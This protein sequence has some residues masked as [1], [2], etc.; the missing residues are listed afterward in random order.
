LIAAPVS[1]RRTASTATWPR[2][3]YCPFT[4]VALFRGAEDLSQRLHVHRLDQMMA[5][6]GCGRSRALQGMAPAGL[7]DDDDVGGAP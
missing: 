5:E 3:G 7:G 1:R 2:L 4:P 6:S